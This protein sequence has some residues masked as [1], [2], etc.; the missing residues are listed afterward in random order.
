MYRK[1]KNLKQKFFK[2]WIHNKKFEFEDFSFYF[3]KLKIIIKFQK[4]Q[5]NVKNR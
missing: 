3:Q 2:K 1:T 5:K 4:T